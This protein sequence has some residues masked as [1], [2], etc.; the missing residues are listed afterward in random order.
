MK[1]GRGGVEADDGGQQS[2]RK[3]CLYGDGSDCVVD[4]C[5]GM[6][7]GFKTV[8]STSSAPIPEKL[9]CATAVASMSTIRQLVVA[10]IQKRL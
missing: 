5:K 3:Q 8:I 7:E 6:Q 9:R 2:Y 1:G 10:G 4:K